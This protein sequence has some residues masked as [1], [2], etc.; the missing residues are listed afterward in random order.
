MGL[1][2]ALQ[3]GPGLFQNTLHIELVT[4]IKEE[5]IEIL[6]VTYFVFTISIV[7]R[8]SQCIYRVLLLYPT[9]QLAHAPTVMTNH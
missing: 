2:W 6:N 3:I 8:W 5:I 9:Q 4:N 1:C 7:T